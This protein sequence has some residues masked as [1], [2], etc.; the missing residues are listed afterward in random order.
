MFYK[1]HYQVVPI[2]MSLTS[3]LHLLLWFSNST[4]VVWHKANFLHHLLCNVWHQDLTKMH[5]FKA[6]LNHWSP[7]NAKHFVNLPKFAIP[8]VVALYFAQIK[9]TWYYTAL[10]WH[11]GNVLQSNITFFFI[12]AVLVLWCT[13]SRRCL[14]VNSPKLFLGLFRVRL[15]Y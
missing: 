3:K 1:I 15:I 9:W 2:C 13:Y 10:H 7:C 14:S 6:R 11:S 4:S 8:Y 5:N 12:V